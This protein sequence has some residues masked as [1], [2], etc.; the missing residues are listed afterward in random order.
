MRGSRIALVFQDLL[1][2]NPSLRIGEQ[3]GEGLIYH[4]GFSAERAFARANQRR[5]G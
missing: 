1:V 3:V 4:R 2:L 5:A